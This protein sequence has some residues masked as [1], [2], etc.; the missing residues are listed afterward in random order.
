MLS[1]SG[2]D[3]YAIY[4]VYNIMAQLDWSI[5]H[6]PAATIVEGVALAHRILHDLEQE[7]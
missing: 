3:A 5:H 1:I 4:L 7:A 6:H 2:L